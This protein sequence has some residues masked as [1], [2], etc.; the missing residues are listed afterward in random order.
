M[1]ISTNNYLGTTRD[2]Y[3]VYDRLDSHL[4]K[5]GGLTKEL[6]KRAI[7]KIY[8]NGKIF[9]VKVIHFNKIIG[10]TNCV[11][12]SEKDKENIIMVY[13]KGRQGLSCMVK[14]RICEPSSDLTIIVRKEKNMENHYTLISAF[15]GESSEPEPWDKSLQMN[16]EALERSKIF[17]STHALVYNPDLIDFERSK[18]N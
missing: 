1:V 7:S 15:F 5:E 14:N 3:K 17:W 18:L 10:M 12:V 8:L 16:P 2:G 11:K 9:K 4:H 6:L 13:R